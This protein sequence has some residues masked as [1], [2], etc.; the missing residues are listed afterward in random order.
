[1]IWKLRRRLTQKKGSGRC[2]YYTQRSRWVLRKVHWSEHMKAAWWPLYSQIEWESGAGSCRFEGTKTVST[3]SLLK[4]IAVKGREWGRVSPCKRT[5]CQESAFVDLDRTDVSTSGANGKSQW[6]R[7]GGWFIWATGSSYA[8]R[9]RDL[10]FFLFITAFLTL[11]NLLLPILL[12]VLQK[13][14]YM[15]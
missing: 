10:R 15:V 3:R 5:D 14:C 11:I 6:Q 12:Y 9:I 13:F 4:G 8:A 2:V 7:S 1:M